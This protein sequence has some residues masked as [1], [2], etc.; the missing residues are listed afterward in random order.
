VEAAVWSG[1]A[2]YEFRCVGRGSADD[3]E[4]HGDSLPPGR[5][6]QGRHDASD[7]A[8]GR[9]VP[10]NPVTVRAGPCCCGND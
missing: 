5:S 2:V 4:F 7:L 3:R 8:A 6:P 9:T 10:N 1:E